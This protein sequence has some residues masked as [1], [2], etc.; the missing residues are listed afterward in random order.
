M[1]TD[2]VQIRCCEGLTFK[3]LFIRYN[4]CFQR[5][6]YQQCVAL[7]RQLAAMELKSGVDFQSSH[8]LFMIPGILD[9]PATAA[10]LR[11]L[12]DNEVMQVR[13]NAA[14]LLYCTVD[15]VAEDSASVGPA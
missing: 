2:A 9:K 8:M 5:K 11:S 7:F 3:Y 10:A 12:T 4:L 1:G 14:E 6:Q 13:P 15:L